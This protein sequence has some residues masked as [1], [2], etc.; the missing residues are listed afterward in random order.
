MWNTP[1]APFSAPDQGA[2]C[3][4]RVESM[5]SPLTSPLGG[6][7]TMGNC[8]DLWARHRT[9][10]LSAALLAIASF[11]SVPLAARAQETAIMNRGDAAVT[12]FSGAKQ[13]GEVPPDLHP[14]DLTFIDTNGATLQ[15][16]DLTGL[17]GPPDGQLAHA[18]VKFQATAGEIGQVFGVT[19]D[20]DTA[21]AT[22]NIYVTST[23]LFGLQ[24]VSSAGDRLVKG[25]PGAK[26]M[27]GQ[28]GLDKG[29]SPGS[30]WKIDGATGF[31]SLFA[32]IEHDGN[33]NAGPGL[34]DIAYDSAT[35]QFF[36][37]DLETGL[38]HRL[39]LD[40]KDLGTFDHGQADSILDRTARIEMF[41][42]G[43]HGSSF[44]R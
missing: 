24:I 7:V 20:G 6:R 8:A 13:L 19:L 43:P 38:I 35:H 18:P 4:I 3:I 21:N 31:V 39:D 33:D 44:G 26:W 9:R 16:F 10:W 32:N 14:L 27:P 23:S 17:G 37:S 30:V 2:E 41:R 29:G 34:G 36:V 42:F 40:G 1:R 25:E 11:V 5:P 28:F 22:P 15:V 12:A